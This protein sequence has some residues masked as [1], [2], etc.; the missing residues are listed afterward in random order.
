MLKSIPL[1]G[2]NSLSTAIVHYVKK[3]GENI[4]LSDAAGDKRFIGDPYIVAHHPKSILCAPISHKGATAGIIYLENNLA[5]H[6]FTPER[7]KLLQIFSAQAAIAIENALLYKKLKRSEESLKESFENLNKVFAT[8]VNAMSLAIE[9]RDPYT[10]GHQRRVAD[11]ASVI[12][13]ELKLPPEMIDGIRIAGIIHD[14]GKISVPAELLTRPGKLTKI[15]F[16]LIKKHPESGYEILQPIAFPWP[17]A[18]IVYQHHERLNGSGYP[19]GLTEKDLLIESKIISVAD[20]VEAMASHRPYRASLGI[21]K[22]L[23]EISLNSGILY[24]RKIVDVCLKLFREK[25]YQ[26]I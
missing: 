15:E 25:G 26:L 5:T 18:Q 10:A 9:A 1:E 8:T 21:D 13:F 19:L 2:S 20:V 11:L 17:I 24:D 6:A 22:A 23:E 14:I 7:L 12:A 3:T 16:S 4:V